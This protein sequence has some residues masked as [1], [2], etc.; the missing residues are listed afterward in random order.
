MSTACKPEN[1]PNLRDGKPGRLQ[2]GGGHSVID[3]ASHTEQHAAS[4][5]TTPHE[6]P[7]VTDDR[8]HW[9]RKYS[10]DDEFNLPEDPIPELAR[11]IDTLPEGRAL[12]VATGTGRNAI[13]SPNAGTASRLSTSPM[14]LSSEPGAAPT[15]GGSTSIGIGLTSLTPSM[16]SRR[17]LTM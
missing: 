7:H 17:T 14:R 5:N 4:F 1:L 10:G 12:D 16:I 8:E 3:K 15:K 13:Y 9:N 2:R 11:R 6:R